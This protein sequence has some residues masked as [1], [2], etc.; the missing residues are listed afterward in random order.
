MKLLCL[1]LVGTCF[2]AIAYGQPTVAECLNLAQSANCSFYTE[3][4]ERNMPC[5]PS[6]YAL[7]YGYPF[8]KAFGEL[9]NEFTTQ[10]QCIVGLRLNLQQATRLPGDALVS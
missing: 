8:C 5:G 3:C 7:G 9:S 6:G 10:V 2:P 1:I 4:V